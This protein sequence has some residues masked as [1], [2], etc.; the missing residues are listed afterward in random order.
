M[1]L[2]RREHSWRRREYRGAAGGIAEPGGICIS[3]PSYQ[4][5]RDKL[6]IDFEDM[7]EQQLK[8]IARPVRVYR[9]PIGG[10][11]PRERPAVCAEN[12]IRVSQVTESAKLARW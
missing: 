2:R 12:P 9:V 1:R 4:Q 6:A 10:S 5:V 11:A 8:N 7:G 3:D